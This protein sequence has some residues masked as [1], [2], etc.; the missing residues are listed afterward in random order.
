MVAAA[1]LQAVGH[2][3]GGLRKEG[4][5]GV[6]T[7]GISPARIQVVAGNPARLSRTLPPASSLPQGEFKGSLIA[8]V[9]RRRAHQGVGCPTSGC[10]IR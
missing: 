3:A 7:L 8:G 5:A 1:P 10:G 4:L 6:Q 2:W 9:R